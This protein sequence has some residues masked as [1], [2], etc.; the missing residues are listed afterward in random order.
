MAQRVVVLG[1]GYAGVLAA[2]RLAGRARGRAAVTLVDAKAEFVQRLRLHQVAAG[3]SV[4]EPPYQKLLGRRVRFVQGA[5]EGIDLDAGT[6]ILSGSRGSPGSALGFDRLIYAAGSSDDLASVPGVLEHAHRVADRASAQRLRETLAGASPGARVLVVGGGLTGIE[7][8]SE[9]AGSS[10]GVHVN[11]MTR[12]AVGGWLT[13]KARACL[14]GAL[15]RLGVETHEQQRVASVE[16]GCVTLADGSLLAFDVLVWCGG[17]RAS[18]VAARSGMQTDELGRLL[19][20]RTMRSLSHPHVVGVGDAAA[21]PPFVAG[22]P[23]RMCCQVASTTY[24]RAADTV[25]AELTGKTPK[26]LHFGYVHQP[27]SIGRR[28]G[29]IQFVDRGDRPTLMING[30]KAAIYKELVSASPFMEM[31]LERILPGANAWP[32]REPKHKG[33]RAGTSQPTLPPPSSQ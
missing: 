14:A 18:P 30:R 27:I 17:F 28:D 26:A 24:V 16:P 10:P 13:E 11:L 7:V 5:A 20:D 22:R 12:G 21:T 31:R 32:I 2:V 3:Q 6:V 25:L 23:L 8:A 19:V 29:L 15:S 33:L 9:L 4:S 1:G